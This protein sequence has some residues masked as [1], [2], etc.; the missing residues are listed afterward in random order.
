MNVNSS[1]VIEHLDH[2]IGK[3]NVELK[4]PP[5]MHDFGVHSPVKSINAYRYDLCADFLEFPL[6]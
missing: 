2:R 4:H 5:T 6:L 1:F 3:D